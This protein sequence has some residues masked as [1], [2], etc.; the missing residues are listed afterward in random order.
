MTRTEAWS[1]HVANALV[2]GT[3][4]VYAWM[5]YLVTPDDPFAL[6]NHPHQ[7]T[8]HA[9]HIVTAP[10]L[11]FVAGVSWKRHVWA[12]VR[13]GY[14]HRRKTGLTLFALLFPMVSSGYLLQVSVDETLRQVYLV[15][16]VA[17]SVLWILTYL[18]HQFLGRPS[19]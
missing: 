2:G 7:P 13:S 5:L 11:V 1:H 17:T 6:V 10:L 18:A 19:G 3:G 16:H 9:L 12:R 4:V 15:T 14:P 8:F